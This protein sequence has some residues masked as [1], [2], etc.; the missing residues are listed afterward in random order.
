[1]HFSK[2]FIMLPAVVGMLF[3]T[4]PSTIQAQNKIDTASFFVD[5]LCKMCKKRIEN[6]AYQTGVKHV[7][8]NIP[9]RELTVVYKT[10]RTSIEEIKENV[11]AAGHDTDSKKASD[12]AYSQIHHCCRYREETEQ[13]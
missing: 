13:H 3:I 12:E 7:N 5:G 1:M 4:S 11:A 9:E 6:A 2:L 8:W 10:R